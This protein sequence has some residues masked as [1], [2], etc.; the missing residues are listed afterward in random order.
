MNITEAEIKARELASKGKADF[1]IRDTLLKSG[2]DP[3]DVKAIMQTLLDEKNKRAFRDKMIGLL[4][5]VLGIVWIWAVFHFD[6]LR[7]LIWEVRSR[8]FGGLGKL[9]I[10]FGP[11]GYGV[12][13]LIKG[14]FKLKKLI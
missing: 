3:Q 8:R 10:V 9:F 14:T 12:L 2:A 13:M 6:V 1:F 7:E 4:G 11:F 5:I